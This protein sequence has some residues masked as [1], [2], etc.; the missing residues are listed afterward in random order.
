MQ[1]H[2]WTRETTE[3][4]Y[5]VGGEVVAFSHA[6]F[7]YLLEILSEKT[8]PATCLSLEFVSKF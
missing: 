6:E 2:P 3:N 8:K 7:I 5:L 1:V 4:F